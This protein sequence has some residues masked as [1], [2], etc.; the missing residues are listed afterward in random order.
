MRRLP[1]TLSTAATT[2]LLGSST[3]SLGACGDDLP[4]Q[5]DTGSSGTTSAAST[6]STGPA[7]TTATTDAPTTTAPSTTA[8]ESTGPSVECG[9]GIVEEGEECDDENV[10][11]DDD[12]SSACTIPFA[13]LWTVSF[14]GGDADIGN[15]A[16]FDADGNLYVLGGIEVNGQDDI[17]LRQY[18]PDGTEGWTWTYNGEFEADDFGRRM[19]W[20][21]DGDLVIVGTQRTEANGDDVLVLRL[22]VADQTVVWSRVV[23]GPG[24]GPDPVDNADFGDAITVDGDG[25]VLVSGTMR[26]D[27]QEYDMWL[28]KLDADGNELWTHEF[29]NPDFNGSDTTDAVLADANGDIYLAGN[30]EVAPSMVQAWVRKLDTDGNELWTQTIPTPVVLTNGTLDGGGNLVLVGFDDDPKNGDMWAGKYD[31]D[32]TELAT[33]THDGPMGQFDAALG[34]ATGGAGDVFVTGYVTIPGEQSDIW[35]GRYQPSLGLRWWSDSYGNT[36]SNLADDGRAVAVS[37]DDS[38]VAVVGYESVIGQD[39]N[40]WVRMYQNNPAPLAQ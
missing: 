14:D 22:A 3:L 34:V 16:L 29:Q 30:I 38:H 1:L 23:D 32:F 15:H 26:V 11:D 7:D 35:V 31:A 25:N 24:S 36:D 17:W 40:I 39:T 10:L 9:N 8:V 13:E 6:G 12:C 27:G 19:A 5:Q 37:D 20:L 33:T 28:R 2:L 4:A 21:P 18:A